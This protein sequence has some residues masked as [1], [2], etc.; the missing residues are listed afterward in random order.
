[1]PNRAAATSTTP[2]PVTPDGRYIVVRGRLWRRANPHLDDDERD[3]L[4]RALMTARREVGAATRRGDDDAVRA[5]RARVDEAK[6]G[7]GERGPVW[8]SDGAPDLNRHLAKNTPYAS[9]FAALEGAAV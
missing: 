6:R 5:A 2:P 9:W 8:W 4:V 3:R 1:M 7:L